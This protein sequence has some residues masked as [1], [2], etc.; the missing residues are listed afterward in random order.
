MC[1][2]SLHRNPRFTSSSYTVSIRSF[3]TAYRLVPRC[4]KVADLPDE[5]FRNISQGWYDHV[6]RIKVRPGQAEPDN[7]FFH[8]AE[9]LALFPRTWD[10]QLD[11][12]KKKHTHTKMT[13]RG[14]SVR[15]AV[16]LSQRIN[17]TILRSAQSLR[18]PAEEQFKCAPSP[19]A[20]K[21]CRNLFPRLWARNGQ[22]AAG[23]KPRSD[24]S[25]LGGVGMTIGGCRKQTTKRFLRVGC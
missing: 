24:R 19:V 7:G 11:P 16:S 23:T 15:V 2:S 8:G 6:F 5:V 13:L 3:D 1:F 21:A 17:L 4:P 20:S 18:L 25:H 22:I 12:Q 10:A 14:M 9:Q